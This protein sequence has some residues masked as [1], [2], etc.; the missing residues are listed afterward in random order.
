MVL[1]PSG[2]KLKLRE[3]LAY[4]RLGL[5]GVEA[6]EGHVLVVALQAVLVEVRFLHE[7]GGRLA[8]KVE[9]GQGA[10]YFHEVRIVALLAAAFAVFLLLFGLVAHVIERVQARQVALVVGQR[11]LGFGDERVRVYGTGFVALQIEVG[12]HR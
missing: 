6:L 5:A 9:H 4:Q 3:R 11:G 12:Q 2:E 7:H 10:D 1:Q 8:H